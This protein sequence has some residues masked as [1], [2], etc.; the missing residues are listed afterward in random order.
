M[1]SIIT[2]LRGNQY[3]KDWSKIEVAQLENDAK[4]ALT[5]CTRKVLIFI[6]GLDEYAGNSKEMRDLCRIILRL[7]EH[8]KA[9]LCL[10]SRKE[11]QLV[12]KFQNL[13]NLHISDYNSQGIGNYIQA[14][15]EHI[16]EDNLG[17]AAV[18]LDQMRSI[19]YRRAEGVFV[20][21]YLALLEIV[22]ACVTGRSESEIMQLAYELPSELEPMYQRII[23]RKDERTKKE[24]ALVYTLLEDMHHYPI[25]MALLA[26]AYQYLRLELGISELPDDVQD[27]RRF[28]ARF[29]ATMGGLYELL[30]VAE[31]ARGGDASQMPKLIHETVRAF[32]RK[33]G[34]VDQWLSPLFRR[35]LPDMIWARLSCNVLA[36]A[37]SYAATAD[38]TTIT[39]Q[40]KASCRDGFKRERL[41]GCPSHNSFIDYI[42]QTCKGRP[43]NRWPL[44]LYNSIDAIFV[45][46][47]DII[48]QGDDSVKEIL[49]CSMTSGWIRLR[50]RLWQ[51]DS[52]TQLL[53]RQPLHQT[54]FPDLVQ[55]AA[56]LAPRYLLSSYDRLAALTDGDR[57]ILC[58]LL[59]QAYRLCP[60]KWQVTARHES[61]LDILKRTVATILDLDTRLSVFHIGVY[62]Y[63]T[64]EQVPSFLSKH[65]PVTKPKAWPPW[66]PPSA[67]RQVA[68]CSPARTPL[69]MWPCVKYETFI[70]SNPFFF[71]ERE[72]LHTLIRFGVD[73]DA[74]TADG[75]NIVHYLITEHIVKHTYL[76][77]DPECSPDSNSALSIEM[78]YWLEEMKANFTSVYEGSTPL[79]ALEKGTDEI[80]AAQEEDSDDLQYELTDIVRTRFEQLKYMLRHKEQT[81]HLPRPMMGTKYSGADQLHILDHYL[82]QKTCT[83]CKPAQNA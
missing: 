53:L 15:L 20:W 42:T 9:K 55:A 6:D 13:P 5:D 67:F 2:Y 79:Q 60:G 8:E 81:G 4:A 78:L 66:C 76:P 38:S 35:E 30:S 51:Y 44:L 16:Q 19:I 22:E 61:E 31:G 59:I 43:M 58:T 39:E 34:W 26:A 18:D 52:Q 45:H 63:L 14:E 36:R 17:F 24:A 57:A 73:I 69:F 7:A 72:Q 74:R 29:N 70:G 23:N 83:V 3:Q 21:V 40:L 56:H 75:M 27:G 62:L 71:Q 49:T 65:E 1:I 32:T 64:Y 47:E 12:N 54:P 50:L 48:R 11:P 25:T 10:A 82:E 28:E 68:F 41:V 80:R 46:C 77:G 37:D 33:T